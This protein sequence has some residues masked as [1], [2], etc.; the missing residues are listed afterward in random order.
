M[1]VAAATGTAVFRAFVTEALIPALRGRSGVVVVM[2][3]S[4]GRNWVMGE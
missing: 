2:D 3:K 4:Y 1:A